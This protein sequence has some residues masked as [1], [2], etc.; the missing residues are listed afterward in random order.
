M[1][2]LVLVMLMTAGPGEA[3]PLDGLR[4]ARLAAAARAFK[5][6]RTL[7]QVGRAQLDAVYRWSVRWREAE[8]KQGSA[9]HLKRMTALLAE[10]KR[11]SAAGTAPAADL[12]AARFYVAEARLWAARRR[13]K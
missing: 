6:H 4:K 5:A 13:G 1:M 3:A 9:A 7:Y 10:V 11:K 8:S 12:A 2:W